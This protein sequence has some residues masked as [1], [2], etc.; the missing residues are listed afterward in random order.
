MDAR[1]RGAV[2]GDTR[3]I[4]G[5]RDAEQRFQRTCVFAGLKP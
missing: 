2:F 5:M 1:V 4:F 3:P